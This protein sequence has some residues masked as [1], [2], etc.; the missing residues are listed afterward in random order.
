MVLL[1][2]VQFHF[3]PERRYFV[4]NSHRRL[5]LSWATIMSKHWNPKAMQCIFM[6]Q[7]LGSLLICWSDWGGTNRIECSFRSCSRKSIM[8]LQTACRSLLRLALW[9]CWH[10]WIANWNLGLPASNLPSQR[11]ISVVVAYIPLREITKF[12]PKS[13][14]IMVHNVTSPTWLDKGLV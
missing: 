1:R 5:Q 2:L 10:F 12:L 3:R 7:N 6:R 14:N 11:T 8:D 13:V 4:V 9:H